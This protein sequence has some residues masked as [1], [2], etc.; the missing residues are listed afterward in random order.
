MWQ[1][2]DHLI[3]RATLCDS[4]CPCGARAQETFTNSVRTL[5]IQFL[6]F[7]KPII[8]CSNCNNLV[9][10]FHMS[11]H[12]IRCNYILRLCVFYILIIFPTL[13][14][15]ISVPECGNNAIFFPPP[16]Y[17]LSSFEKIIERFLEISSF[18]GTN[19]LMFWE[20]LPNFFHHKIQKKKK[21]TQAGNH[22]SIWLFE[23]L[24]N[25]YVN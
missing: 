3:C 8:I 4:P 14:D 17:I 6:F 7:L 21:K 9:I 24:Q 2:Q 13:I 10:N 23:I 19:L 20:I 18:S 12:P 1:V 25:L 5:I 16:Q 11:D 15:V 22:G